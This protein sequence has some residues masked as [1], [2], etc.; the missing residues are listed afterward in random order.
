VVLIDELG[1][2]TSQEEGEAIAWAV[3]ESLIASGA[4]VTE[5]ESQR[6]SHTERERERERDA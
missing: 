6:E 1:R 2:G 5:R 3:S 4:Y